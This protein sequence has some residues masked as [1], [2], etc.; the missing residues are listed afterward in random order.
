MGVA[1]VTPAAPTGGLSNGVR[2]GHGRRQEWLERGLAPRWSALLVGQPVPTIEEILCPRVALSTPRQARSSSPSTRTRRTDA[3]WWRSGVSHI[4][5]DAACP[6]V[7]RG[8]GK[9]SISAAVSFAPDEWNIRELWPESW[10]SGAA[11]QR[12]C[13]V[14][15][16]MRTR[17][18]PL[19]SR[20]GPRVQASGESAS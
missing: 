19:I 13:P 15:N 7:P 14:P 2:P 6:V 9:S 5:V 20:H 11:W 1:R 12:D 4:S 3:S 17:D 10:E 16:P 18:C 8:L